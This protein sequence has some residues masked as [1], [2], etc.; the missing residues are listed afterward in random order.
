MASDS[1][2]ASLSVLRYRT[3]MPNPSASSQHP[4]H[5]PRNAPAKRRSPRLDS[6]ARKSRHPSRGPKQQERIQAGTDAGR[7]EV[8]LSG[9]GGHGSAHHGQ[10][11][12]QHGAMVSQAKGAKR[13]EQ[14]QTHELAAWRPE[15]SQQIRSI[16]EEAWTLDLGAIRLAAYT[17]VSAPAAWRAKVI[18]AGF[19]SSNLPD[20]FSTI[21]EA[22]TA[23][24]RE[25]M[26]ILGLSAILLTKIIKERCPA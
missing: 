12:V 10:P 20:S 24:E 18:V 6:K 4:D 14:G 25:G 7:L 26:T 5:R 9:P 17:E 16:T 22:M 19:V 8:L 21:D 2:A 23:A 1:P 3:P 15:Q 13:K 11:R